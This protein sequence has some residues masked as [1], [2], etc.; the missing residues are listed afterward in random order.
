MI[1]LLHSL[2]IPSPTHFLFRRGGGER[3]EGQGERGEGEGERGKG[4]GGREDEGRGREAGRER[5]REGGGSNNG[6][7]IGGE[8]EREECVIHLPPR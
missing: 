4:E 2:R 1:I 5:E 8:G 6:G 3:G 7:W